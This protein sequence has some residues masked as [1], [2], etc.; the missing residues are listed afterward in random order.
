MNAVQATDFSRK[1]HGASGLK[2]YGKEWDQTRRDEKIASRTLEL[3]DIS[4]TSE[5]EGGNG[6]D[7]GRIGPDR[8]FVRCEPDPGEHR[9][10]GKSY[11]FC[12]ALWNPLPITRKVS[13]QIAAHGW[14]YFGLQTQHYTARRGN[15]SRVLGAEYC[16]R[17]HA[18]NETDLVEI[19]ITLPPGTAEDPVVVVSNFHWNRYTELREW[20]ATLPAGAERKD[21]GKSADGRPITAVEIGNPSKPAILIAQTSQPSELGCTP[22]IQAMITHLLQDTGHAR[23]LRDN[24][25]FCFLPMTNPDG[26]V[27]GLTVSTPGGRF[28]VFEGDKAVRGDADTVHEATVLWGYLSSVKPAIYW[29][30]HTNNWSRRPGNML[31]RYR[32]T[33]IED[34]ARQRAWAELED[35]ML[36]L[37]DTH[38]ENFTA[39]GEGHYQPTMGFQATTQLGAISCIVKHHEKYPI[40]DSIAFGISCL[41]LA[42]AQLMNLKS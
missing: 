12:F 32:H 4:I 2:T 39:H 15:A 19:D 37:P 20:I 24:L 33:L 27:R 5:F 36:R 9:F 28:P 8:Y 11:Y 6:M 29:E 10:S 17:I 35:A 14:N 34:P 18:D 1:H 25:R 42:A 26:Q 3:D 13:V 21:V 7:M 31:L 23:S 40:Q 30:W 38:H 16:R 22:V 41:E